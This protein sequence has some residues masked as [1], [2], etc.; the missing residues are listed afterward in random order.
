MKSFIYTC[1][2]CSQKLEC[3]GT[4]ANQIIDCPNCGNEIVPTKILMLDTQSFA[5][6][7]KLPFQK[8]ASAVAKR[9]PAPEFESDPAIQENT[10][11]HWALVLAFIPF[12]GIIAVISGIVAC[13]IEKEY[14]NKRYKAFAVTGII[15]GSIT[16]LT[17]LILASLYA[18]YVLP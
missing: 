15:L 7:G 16:F 8:P 13:R 18:A 14:P 11:A 5:H 1:P 3:D 4:L 12:L 17:S 6:G 10:Y 2:H 9:E